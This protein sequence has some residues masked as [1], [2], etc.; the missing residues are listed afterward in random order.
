MKNLF[1]L[2]FAVCITTM[3]YAQNKAEDIAK[4]TTE[5]VNLGKIQQNVAA[6]ATFTVT[7]ISKAPLIIESASPSCGCTVSD[8]TKEPIMPGKS[9]VITAKYDAAALNNFEKHVNVK[10][11]GVN[12]IKS[13]TFKGE[14]L[15]KADFAKQ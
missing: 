3:S 8:F 2:L 7:N 12:E 11:A 10:F 15:S 5:T 6:V 4:F 14:V 9:G 1:I 13:I